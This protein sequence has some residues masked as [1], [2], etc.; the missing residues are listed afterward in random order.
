[1]V[2][3]SPTRKTGGTGLGLSICLSLI[4][5]HGG[6]IGLLNSEVGKGSTFFF[7][8]PLDE[9][10]AELD[11]S[12]LSHEN[13]VILSIDDDAQ[14][15]ALYERYL[16]SSGYVVI[17]ETHPTN[18]VKRAIELNPMAITLDIMMP[19]KDGWQVMRDLKSNEKTRA[20]PI[21]ICSILEE[22]E[23]G[24]SLGATDYLVKPFMQDDLIKSLQR[25]DKDG[26]VHE[27][28]IVDDDAGDL[29]LTQKMIENGGNYHV[30]TVQSGKDALDELN[31]NTPDAIILDLFM[32]G[33]NGFDLLE[34]FRTDPRLNQIPVIILT[35]ADLNPEQQNQLSEFDKHLF[36]KGMLKEKDLLAY[37]EESLNKIKSQNK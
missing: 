15:I 12:Q 32:P 24:F 19:E 3:D 26:T 27:V 21:L 31:T 6:R 13:N 2:D 4:E 7:T 25:I 9:T 14:V 28:L 30:T 29:R 5:L 10:K 33:L 35:G 1:Q 17:P 11:L 34:I 37:I 8:L 16:Q 36:S 23:K 20:I 22:E 18:A